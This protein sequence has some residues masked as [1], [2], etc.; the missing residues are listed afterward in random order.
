MTGSG[1]DGLL[2]LDLAEGAPGGGRARCAL[3]A[4][5]LGALDAQLLQ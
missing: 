5:Q 3:A 4:G 1:P 2:Q